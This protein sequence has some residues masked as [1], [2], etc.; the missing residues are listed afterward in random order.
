MSPLSSMPFSSPFLNSWAW[1]DR[2]SLLCDFSVVKLDSNS[3]AGAASMA[4]PAPQGFTLYDAQSSPDNGSSLNLDDGGDPEMSRFN[5]MVR[6][7]LQG[8]PYPLFLALSPSS[9]SLTMPSKTT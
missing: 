8:L 9:P 5:D 1:S 2:Y 6:E 4:P 7:Y 3:L